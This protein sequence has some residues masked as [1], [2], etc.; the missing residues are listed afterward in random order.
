[1]ISVTTVLGSMG[2]ND[3]GS[4]IYND[5]TRKDR[6]VPLDFKL[7]LPSWYFGLLMNDKGPNSQRKEGAP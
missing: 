6:K 1:M 3:H 5:L 7:C 4:R 2:L